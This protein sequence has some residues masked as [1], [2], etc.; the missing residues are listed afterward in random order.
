MTDRRPTPCEDC[1]SREIATQTV[2][3]DML[4]TEEFNA[5]PF[6]MI[7]CAMCG[8]ER[9]DLYLFKP[10][11]V[12]DFL[13]IFARSHRSPGPQCKRPGLRQFSDA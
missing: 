4:F 1:G 3:R 10:T 13:V 2:T 5:Q 7:L 6:P 9:V 12:S 8:G 11:L